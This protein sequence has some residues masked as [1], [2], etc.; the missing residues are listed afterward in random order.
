MQKI[1]KLVL[2]IFL[3]ILVLY[4]QK[5]NLEIEIEGVGD[6]TV[7]VEHM[8]ISKMGGRVRPTKETLTCKDNKLLTNLEVKEPEI[9]FV[10]FKKAGFKRVSRNKDYRPL[11]KYLLLLLEPNK[12]IS[13]KG[14][15]Y[16]Y[17]VDYEVKGNNFSKNNAKLQKENIKDLVESCKVELELDTLMF[18]T[19]NLKKDMKNKKAIEEN[20]IKIKKLFAKRREFFKQVSKRNLE[21]IKGNLDKDL[22]GYLLTRQRLDIFNEYYQKLSKAVRNGICKNMLDNTL[23]RYK[24]SLKM[25]EASKNIVKGKIAPNFKLKSFLGTD[26]SLSSIKDKYIVLDFWGSWCGWCIKGLPK[27]KEYYNKY[28][29]RIEFIGICCRDTKENWIKT[30]KEHKLEWTNLLNSKDLDTDLSVIYGISGFPTKL[31]LD[32]DKKIIA[33]IVGESEEFYKKLDEIMKK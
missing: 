13:V 27:M 19:R 20:D 9:V 26:F 23:L 5:N 4:G 31:I 24:K 30:I 8:P 32:K 12:K 17:Y 2:I 3:P 28:K 14:K 22:S 33:K 16:K 1:I 6:D 21:Y 29:D 25:K 18:D 7:Y 10:F 11:S 15:M